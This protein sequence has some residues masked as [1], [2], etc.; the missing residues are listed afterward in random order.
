M[1][2]REYYREITDSRISYEIV[3]D[4]T[5]LSLVSI[6]KKNR[7]PDPIRVNEIRDQM[8]ITGMCDG[9][10]LL[11]I[12]DGK[13]V[14]YDGAHRLIACKEYF[15]GGGVH[16]RIICDSSETEV[17][18]EFRRIN[19]CIPV[20]ELYFST[21]EI[22]VYLMGLIQGIVKGLTQTYSQYTSTSRRP[23]RPN[24][25]RDVF[26]DELSIILKGHIENEKLTTMSED[27]IVSLLQRTNDIIRADH[28]SGK[29]RLKVPQ[30]VLDKCEKSKFYM[31]AGD[32]KSVLSSLL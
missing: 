20:P 25:N 1:L 19:K 10:I 29:N 4:K 2:G 12:I 5:R 30:K 21:E 18:N 14:C 27:D 11:A 24:F 13:C 28:Y 22:N 3:T 23:N 6:W 15:P 7:P 26:S 17:T 32:W 16:V 8:E 31:F 9:Q